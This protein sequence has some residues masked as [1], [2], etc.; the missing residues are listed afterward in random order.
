MKHAVRWLALT[1]AITGLTSAFP[2]TITEMHGFANNDGSTPYA[3]LMQ[4]SDGNFYGTT[5]SGGD[6]G[7][8]C[9]HG[10]DGTV[11]K[12]TPQGQFTLLHTFAA[13]NASPFYPD[14]RNPRGGLVEGPDG[15]LYGTTDLGGVPTSNGIVYRISKSG[16]FQ[17]L[18]DFCTGNP[19]DGA[20]PRGSL[21]LGDDGYFWGT[22]TAPIITPKVFRINSSGD[23]HVVLSLINTGLGTPYN[24]LLRGSDGNYY[25]SASG[26][27]YR[28]T[29]TGQ[30]TPLYFFT[31]WN[32]GQGDG[33]GTDALIQ[34]TDGWL[35]GVTYPGAV[36]RIALDGTYQKIRNLD[37]A[38]TG[39]VPNALIQASDGNLWG[40]CGASGGTIGT[41]YSITTTGTFVQ[42]VGMT[43]AT[44]GVRP[45]APLIQASD[46]RLYGTA[47]AYGVLPGGSPTASGTV[48]VV[49][50]G[51]GAAVPGEAGSTVGP[52]RVTG[53]DG[54]TGEISVSYRPA[55][56]ATDTH[57]VYGP[58]SAVAT[59]GYTGQTCGLGNSGS[60]RFNPGSG[61]GFWVIVGNTLT[62]EGSYGRSS[63][64]AER[65][66]AIGLPGCAYTR[67]LSSACP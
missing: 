16:Q 47:S 9:V 24:G 27:V 60:A 50:A 26:G 52:M 59:Y 4:A 21:V 65:P 62:L 36:F 38:T 5:I 43:Q 51:L 19:C 39:T 48:Y 37:P 46:G 58:L 11:F 2:A 1:F 20:N 31:P 56:S 44:S 53:F 12:I 63:S 33:S 64:G 22:V 49:D 66:Q 54:A 29:S 3:P 8:G 15:Y 28:V 55:C 40:T 23:Y 57:I 61:N 67:D 7:A 17:K 13:G 42:S 6:D 32:G 10:C 35:Y 34:A 45:E 30:L 18:H 25:G 41:V 14:G